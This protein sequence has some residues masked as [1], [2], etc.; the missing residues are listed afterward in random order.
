MLIKTNDRTINLK[1]VSNINVIKD[2][3]RIVFNFNHSIDISNKVISGYYY[4][5]FH[6]TVH[7]NGG[8]NHL[9]NN[10]YI[11]ENFITLNDKAGFVNINEISSIKFIEHKNR[12]IFNLSNAVTFKDHNKKSSITSEFVYANLESATSYNNFVAYVNTLTGD[13]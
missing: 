7:F 8:L 3:N 1:N 9:A 2:R 6:D 13:N 4:W 5:D 12:V 11:S 10:A